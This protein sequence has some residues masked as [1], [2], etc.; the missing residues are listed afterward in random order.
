MVLWFEK[1]VQPFATT[2]LKQPSSYIQGLLSFSIDL[3]YI[4][5]VWDH[6]SLFQEPLVP[7]AYPLYQS[8]ESTDSHS[9]WN[10]I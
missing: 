1:A 7:E 8:R 10:W 4:S 3:K 5:I 6:V 2:E 9:Y